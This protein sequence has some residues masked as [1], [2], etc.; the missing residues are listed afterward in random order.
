M[1]LTEC[2]FP[3]LICLPSIIINY[4]FSSLLNVQE[5]SFFTY[6]YIV[7]ISFSSASSLQHH[8]QE[9]V[10]VDAENKEVNGDS[11]EYDCDVND[12]CEEADDGKYDTE[13]ET[14]ETIETETETEEE[15]CDDKPDRSVQIIFILVIIYCS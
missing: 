12:E 15:D 8:T 5:F 9:D 13:T 1:S 14:D 11:D 3:H 6:M 10:T 2:S 4:L 7:Y